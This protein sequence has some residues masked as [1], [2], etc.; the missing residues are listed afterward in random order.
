MNTLDRSGLQA[1]AYLL[2]DFH[3]LANL[4]SVFDLSRVEISQVQE[5]CTVNVRWNLVLDDIR[6]GRESL[7]TQDGREE[8]YVCRD[9]SEITNFAVH[10]H[11]HT[12]PVL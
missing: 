6:K 3:T 10:A 11:V 2:K 9:E 5:T 4:L 1:V 8:R 7:C 12:Q